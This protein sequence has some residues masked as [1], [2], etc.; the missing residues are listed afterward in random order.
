ML[1]QTPEAS[2]QIPLVAETTAARPR[3]ARRSG[4]PLIDNSALIAFRSRSNR[5]HL[6]VKNSSRQR[7]QNRRTSH[8]RPHRRLIQATGSAIGNDLDVPELSMTQKEKLL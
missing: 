4:R 5:H 6:I 3:I 1:I 8:V 7:I 2:F